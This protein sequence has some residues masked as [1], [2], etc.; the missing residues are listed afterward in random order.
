[1][2]E[3]ASAEERPSRRSARHRALQDM[4]HLE[5][6]GET[7]HAVSKGEEVDEDS[8]FL[9]LHPHLFERVG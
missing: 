9:Q 2:K 8:V 4:S 3:K 6:D 1:M 5:P 7:V